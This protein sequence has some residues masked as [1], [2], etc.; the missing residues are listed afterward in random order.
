VLVNNAGLSGNI[1]GQSIAKLDPDDFGRIL[2]VNSYAPLRVSAAFLDLVAAS[3]QRKIVGMSSGL[4]SL[5]SVETL[6]SSG[7]PMRTTTR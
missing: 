3:K 7:Y 4:G 6:A 1:E 5:T 2:R